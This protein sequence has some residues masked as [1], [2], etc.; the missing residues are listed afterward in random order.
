MTCRA[1][2]LLISVLIS[3]AAVVAACEGCER[4]REVPDPEVPSS[5]VQFSSPGVDSPD[6]ARFAQRW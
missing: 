1:R 5:Q 6:H 2:L 3:F 4:H